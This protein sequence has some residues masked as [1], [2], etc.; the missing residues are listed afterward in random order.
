MSRNKTPKGDPFKH[1]AAAM[2]GLSIDELESEHG[3]PEPEYVG[4]PCSFCGKPSEGYFSIHRDGFSEGPEVP[5]CIEC[6]KGERPTCEEIWQHI[7][8]NGVAGIKLDGT[9]ASVRKILGLSETARNLSREQ[10]MLRWGCDACGVRRFSCVEADIYIRITSPP[11]EGNW[12]L[13]RA[14]VCE[15]CNNDR[16]SQVTGSEIITNALVKHL[17]VKTLIFRAPDEIV[18]NGLDEWFGRFGLSKQAA[19]NREGRVKLPE[20]DRD[21][22]Q[23]KLNRGRAL[24]GQLPE[25]PGKE[26]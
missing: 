1:A 23:Q 5:L 20:A 21:A 24:F 2:L 12:R 13:S 14:M 26:G 6:G 18:W 22:I 3:D 16:P 17:P 25:P 10:V 19:V 11:I 4:K 8:E 15:V 9:E 7:S